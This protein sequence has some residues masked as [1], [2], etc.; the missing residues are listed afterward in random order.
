MNR[1]PTHPGAILRED[2]LPGLNITRTAFAESI[3][4]S[5][6]MLHG[7]LSERRP[8]TPETAI[9]LSV[10]LGNS[11]EMWLNMQMKYDVWEK[12]KAMTQVLRR[13]KPVI[14]LVA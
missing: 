6:T 14:P 10:A 2:I 11:P 7:I 13:I 4:I 12:R 3:Q 8:I 9:K 1:Q 5:R